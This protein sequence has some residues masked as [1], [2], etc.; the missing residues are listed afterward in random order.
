MKLANQIN[1]S[2]STTPSDI[3]LPNVQRADSMKFRPTVSVI[4]PTLNEAHNL[5]LVL[6]YLPMNWIDE[7]ILVDGRSTDNT[8][9]VAKKILPSIKIV[10][11]TRKGKGIAMQTGYQASFGD[12]LIVLDADG[13]NDPREIP[14]YISALLEGSDLA[15]GSRFAPGGGTTDM[16]RY[17]ML[18]NGFFVVLANLFFGVNFTDLCY[19]YHAFWRAS[20]EKI[21]LDKYS[22]FEIDTALYLQAVRSRLRVV[23]VP[24]FEGYRFY[25]VGKLKAVPDGFRVLKTLFQQWKKMLVGKKEQL[26]VGF[27]GIRYAPP[28]SFTTNQYIQTKTS[29][30]GRIVEIIQL[31]SVLAISGDNTNTIMDRV[32]EMILDEFNAD[33]GSV[34]LLDENNKIY[35]CCL[36]NNET[37][38]HP[39]PSTWSDLIEHGAAGWVVMNHQPVLIL[40]TSN[41]PRWLHRT[42]DKE[43]RSAISLPIRSG[44]MVIGALTLVRAKKTQFNNQDLEML[45]LIGGKDVSS[46]SNLI[47]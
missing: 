31:L 4:I 37:I 32:L 36:A 35:N 45:N 42:W 39:E 1:P 38:K 26:P 34:I 27:R 14:R 30:R 47:Q 24:S 5:P 17:R 21:R 7:V 44:G 23:E 43:K 18:G 8:I 33:S 20:L 9:E 19:G 12:I 40:D 29:N 10:L 3:E 16:P 22:G 25:G 11:E 41:D 13:S 46:S 15:K 28:D 6:P 2:K